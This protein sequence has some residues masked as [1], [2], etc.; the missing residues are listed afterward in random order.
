MATRET[1]SSQIGFVFAAIGSAVGLGA[2]WK[3][4]Y[5]I[6]HEGGGGFL[7]MYGLFVLLLGIPFYWRAHVRQNES[8]IGHRSFPVDP[9]LRH[10]RVAGWL[11]VISSF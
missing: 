6:G 5:T 4:P 8:P 10:R 11:G 7:L 1:W 2:L 3:I 9:T